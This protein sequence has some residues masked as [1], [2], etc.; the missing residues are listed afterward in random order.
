[1]SGARFVLDIP[2]FNV[3]DKKGATFNA[4]NV[5]KSPP[6]KVVLAKRPRYFYG[7]AI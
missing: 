7:E 4:P 5:S 6:S 2:T 3:P 1:M